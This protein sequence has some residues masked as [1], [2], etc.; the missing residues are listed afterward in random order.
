METKLLTHI[1]ATVNRNLLGGRDLCAMLAECGITQFNLVSAR[2]AF[3]K[4]RTG[5]LGTL[6]PG[7]AMI[8]NLTEM[9]TF[10]VDPREEH[11]ALH[12]IVQKFNLTIP[13]SG[14]V[15]SDNLSIAGGDDLYAA[16]KPVVASGDKAVLQSDIIGIC[17]IVQRGEGEAIARTVLNSGISSP[18]ISYGI[19]TGLRDKVG[20]FRITIPAEK[21]VLMVMTDSYGAEQ[22]FNLLI[23]AGK[24][25]EPGKGFIYMWEIGDGLIDPKVSEGVSLH[26]ANMDQIIFAVDEIKGNTQWR[27]KEANCRPGCGARKY[28]S[29]L[30]GMDILCNEGRG[31]E[32]TAAA[33]AAGAAGATISKFRYVFPG[34]I[35]EG[36]PSPAR[37][38][39]SMIVGEKQAEG[40]AQ[41]L[42]AAGLYDEKTRGQ[43][44]MKKVSKA[45]TYL[46]KPS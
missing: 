44:R 46:G 35:G 40:I 19:G 34:E 5:L 29:G 24:L 11:A 14:S 18:V 21:E 41:A 36:R 13:G 9:I 45:C 25:D 12:A 38:I 2:N 43:I 33:M 26:A 30:M 16:N 7:R 27:R 6:M 22:A 42:S 8:S 31:D 32:L 10:L 39:C 3:L 37:E 20:I 1:T 4:E 15:Y 17:C 28:L 23:D